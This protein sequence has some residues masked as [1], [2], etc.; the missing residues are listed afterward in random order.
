MKRRSNFET[1]CHAS[2]CNLEILSATI[3]ELSFNPPRKRFYTPPV[4]LAE[5]DRTLLA[6]RFYTNKTG[7]EAAALLGI[8]ETAAH[9]RTARALEK[10]RSFFAKRGVD[11]TTAAIA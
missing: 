11:S 9:K 5:R 6:M 3:R 1:P 2:Y 8:R 4:R 7:A 10:L